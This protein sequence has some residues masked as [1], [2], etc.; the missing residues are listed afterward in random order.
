MQDKDSQKNLLLAIVLSVAVLLAWQVFYAGPKLK[1]EQERRQRIQ[2]EQQAAGKGSSP[3]RRRRRP[4][5]ARHGAAAGQ[6]ACPSARPAAPAATRE[7]ALQAARA[8]ASRPRACKGSIALKG[9]RIDDLVLVKYRETVDPKSPNVVLFSPS[10]APASLLRRVRL[11]GRPPASTQPMP[12]R[13]TVWRVERAAV[14]TPPR[15]VTLAWDN[16][17][18]LVF[19]RTIAVDADY[20]FTVTDEVENKTA[21]EV[22]LYPYALISR[23]GTPKTQGF[24][25]LHEGPIG[26]LGEAGLQELQL[27][28]PAEGRRHQDLQADRRLAR[29]HRQVLGRGPDPRPEDA[30]R[31]QVQRHQ[32]Q[33]RIRFQTDYLL[34]AASR[35]RPAATAEQS[36]NLFAGAKQMTLIEAYGDKLGAKQFDLLIDWGWFYFITKPLFKLLHW[37]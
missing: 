1:E 23:H 9:G 10:G 5:R 13:D 30:L 8:C 2:Q 24:Y 12:G 17:Q 34:T 7:A 21:G 19:R 3:A 36:S 20:L 25:I 15:P 18:G 4:G 26:V 28:R 35:S 31:G 33:P 37:L 29:H 16:G 22:T 32:G 14:L 11:G 6:P 27:H